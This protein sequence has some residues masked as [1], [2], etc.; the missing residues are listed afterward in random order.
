MS[1]DPPFQEAC[2]ALFKGSLVRAKDEKLVRVEECELPL[3]DMNCLTLGHKDREKCMK[4]MAQAASEWGFFQVVNHGISQGVLQSL[5]CEQIKVFHEPLSKKTKENFLNLPSNSYR[6]GNPDATCLRQFS[7]S[8][9]L[10]I[11]L[12]DI[13]RM[14]GYK[15]TLRY[16]SYSFISDNL[17]VCFS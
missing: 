7:W 9:A 1:I 8:E 10:H 12:A 6:W 15:T 13:S 3:I 17:F 2:N 5:I 11:S 14:D 4:Q 16:T